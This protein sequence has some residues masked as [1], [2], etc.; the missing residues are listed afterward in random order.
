MVSFSKNATILVIEDNPITRKVSRVALSA[1]GF[2]V[3]E[4]PDAATALALMASQPPDLVLQDLLLPDMDGFEL[5]R[6][7]REL[8]G[9]ETIPIVV[10]SGFLSKLEQ[11]RSL[12]VGFTDYLFKPVEPAHLVGT[13][14]AYL[15]P[16]I[17]AAGRPGSGRHILLADDDPLQL[18]L[19]KVR[20]EQLGFKVSLAADGVEALEQARNCRPDAVVSDI[21]MPRLDGFRLCLAL[22]QEPQLAD[23]PVILTSAVYTEEKDRHL[24]GR[25]GASALI[26]RTPDSR[27]VAETLLRC[28]S[29]ATAPV[30][31]AEED[32]PQA[33]ALPLEEYTHRVIRQLEHQVNLSANLTRRVALLEAELGILARVVETLKNRAEAEVVLGELL[34]RC[35]DAAGISRGAAYL[36]DP[37]GKLSLEAQLGYPPEA[38]EELRDFFGHSH[39]L[40][41]ALQQGEPVDIRSPSGPSD[42]LLARA[43]ARSILVTPLAL[44]D[45]SLG[46][47]SMMSANRELGEDWLLFARAVGSQVAQALELAHTLS[48]LSRSERRYRDLVQGLNAVVWEADVETWQFTFVSR[49]V[50]TLLGYPLQRWLGEPGFW[51]RVIHPEDHAQVRSACAA[52]VAEGQGQALEYRA[53]TADGSL[54]WLDDTVSAVPA[55]ISP[56][57]GL[58][59]RGVMTDGT[60]RQ[61]LQERHTQMRLARRIQQGLFPTGPLQIPGLDVAGLSCPAEDAGGDYY[62]YFL[63]PAGGPV[64]VIG[65]T[66]GHGFGP[67]L[68]MAMTRSYL[69]AFAQI[70]TDLPTILSQVNR[71]LAADLVDDQ[72]VTLLLA[73]FDPGTRT[74]LYASAG[75]TTGYVLNPAGEPKAS[76]SSL[77]LPLGID[78]DADYP[79]GG[80]FNLAPGDLLLLLTDGVVEARAPDGTAFGVRRALDIVRSYRADSAA[81]IA[82]NLYHAVRAFSQNMPQDDDITAVI[83]KVLPGT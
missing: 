68:A 31:Q 80:P 22:R 62:D 51:F 37:D 40:H 39:V 8:P 66:S 38:H 30:I 9:C 25:V 2:T 52:A 55:G 7:L 1:E 61:Q 56:G 23:V 48:R 82:G 46:V 13:V 5:V 57:T 74:L 77:S 53:E 60:A 43:D 64:I 15:R 63:L 26:L 29:T 59:V 19:Q 81:G 41:R 49:Q 69:R 14:K 58:R 35:L 47:L 75:H 44:G 3:V 4:A 71:V 10:I 72:F 78:R 45:T 70:H 36:L 65:D 12:Q 32:S 50:E 17:R 73:R 76:L 83:I 67:A 33:V 16:L 28:F 11:A 21:L 34:F 54:L 24:A 20:L 18:K 27:E 42:D 6:L 79:T